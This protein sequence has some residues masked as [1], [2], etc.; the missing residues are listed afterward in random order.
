MKVIELLGMLTEYQRVSIYPADNLEW[1][2][3][4]PYNLDAEKVR[5]LKWVFVQTI[6]QRT[7]EHIGSGMDENETQ[8]NK[9]Y[10]KICYR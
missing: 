4:N 1:N 2:G 10:L 7:V 6:G 9:S 5:D 3:D 8:Y